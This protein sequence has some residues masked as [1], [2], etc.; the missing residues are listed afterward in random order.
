MYAT[1]GSFTFFYHFR[2]LGRT[3]GP[4][5]TLFRFNQSSVLA[6]C[7]NILQYLYILVNSYIYLTFLLGQTGPSGRGGE[8][9]SMIFFFWFSLVHNGV[10]EF[11]LPDTVCFGWSRLFWGGFFYSLHIW[12][13]SVTYLLIQAYFSYFSYFFVPFSYV[14]GFGVGRV[15]AYYITDRGCRNVTMLSA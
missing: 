12:H 4:P 10:F 7:P 15:D 13:S 3:K 6:S 8:H 14:H 2:P 11:Y 1:T 9:F 5:V